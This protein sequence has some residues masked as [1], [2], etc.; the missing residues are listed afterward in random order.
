[1]DHRFAKE[2]NFPLRPLDA[3]IR[4]YNA[5]GTRNEAGDIK[6]CAV[7]EVEA[8]HHRHI[9]RFLITSL[10]KEPIIL[11]LPWL[12]RV[13]ANIDFTKGT[14]DIDPARVNR[15]IVE[16]LRAMWFPDQ[17]PF[18]GR[19]KQPKKKQ[20]KKQTK[21]AK[22]RTRKHQ[23]KNQSTRTSNELPSPT[24]TLKR[25]PMIKTC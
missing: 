22:T 18:T 13:N 3:P 9:V 2:H 17:D 4:V 19:P 8:G 21:K 1:M 6:K 5:D 10:G 23:P 20:T 14:L 12:Q 24:C 7:L 16:H 11:G 15:T 25:N